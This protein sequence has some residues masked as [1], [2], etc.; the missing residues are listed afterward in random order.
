[1]KAYILNIIFYVLIGYVEAVLWTYIDDDEMSPQ[2]K[3][4]FHKPLVLIRTCFYIPLLWHIGWI[5]VAGL[6]MCYPFWHLGVMYWFRNKLNP[7]IYKA[8]FFA[9]GSATSTA[10]MDNVKTV[11]WLKKLL[12]IPFWVR[13][14]GTVAGTILYFFS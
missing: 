8:R 4:A 14:V 10:A 1:M 11:S 5:K 6:F 2:E 3:K 7:K 9:N 12:K 13:A